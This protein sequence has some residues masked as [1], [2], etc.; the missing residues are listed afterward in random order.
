M[1]A[2]IKIIIAALLI[3]CL[4]NVPFGYFQFI[5]VA[6]FLGFTYLAVIEFENNRTI[7][8]IF[9]A[10]S[11]IILN[12]IFKIHFSRRTWNDIDLVIVFGLIVWIVYEAFW[13]K[14]K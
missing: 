1:N 5:R 3:G 8:G 12:P 7:T 6:G 2:I 11:A 13:K 4:F 10:S 9:T 14:K